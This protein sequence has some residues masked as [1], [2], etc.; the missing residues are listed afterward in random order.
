MYKVNGQQLMENRLEAT[1]NSQVTS[2]MTD[3][4]LKT[5]NK[6]IAGKTVYREK[7]TFRIYLY[8]YYIWMYI[9]T[10]LEKHMDLL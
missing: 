7:K 5:I 6:C 9:Y 8:L 4:D 3:K 2:S 1:S 10:H